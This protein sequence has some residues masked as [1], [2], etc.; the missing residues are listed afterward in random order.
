MTDDII[1]RKAAIDAVAELASSMS[2]CISVDECHGMKRMQGMAVRALEELPSAQL[3]V[4]MSERPPEEDGR[5]LTITISGWQEVI[6]Y[7]NHYSDVDEF[8]LPQDKGGWYKYDSEYGYSEYANMVVAW[9]PIEPW[10]GEKE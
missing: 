6:D 10:K 8:D 1:S 9:M 5:Y 4:P 3:W 2:V 7:A